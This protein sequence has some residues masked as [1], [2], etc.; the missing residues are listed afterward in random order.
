[1]KHLLS[2]LPAVTERVKSMRQARGGGGV[3]DN[4]NRMFASQEAYL[5]VCQ[6]VL[7]ATALLA[8]SSGATGLV[9]SRLL[10]CIAQA[11][12]SLLRRLTSHDSQRQSWHKPCPAHLL[13]DSNSEV[14]LAQGVSAWNF[15]VAALKEQAAR[16]GDHPPMP[17][18]SEAPQASAEGG[19]QSYPLKLHPS[20]QEM[21]PGN[22][23]SSPLSLGRHCVPAALRSNG[24][25]IV[26]RTSGLDVVQHCRQTAS[27]SR[28]SYT[29]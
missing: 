1:M 24:A 4:K 17:T 11:S 12:L 8:G 23:E 20:G 28:M 18:I 16:E 14:W 10:S 15:D 29:I 26:L 3:E 6:T 9:A 22:G 2:D 5:K 13:H 19:P 25:H 7:M 21:A 27:V